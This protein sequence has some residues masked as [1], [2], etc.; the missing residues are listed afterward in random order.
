MDA[1]APDSDA[2]DASIGVNVLITCD[3]IYNDALIEPFVYTCAQ[4]FV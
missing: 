2:T 1:L 3:F 4:I